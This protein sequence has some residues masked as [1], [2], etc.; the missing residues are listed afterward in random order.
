MKMQ[1]K[2]R[3][4]KISSLKEACKTKDSIISKLLA[5]VKNLAKS[6]NKNK[7]FNVPVGKIVSNE[8]NHTDLSLWDIIS[9]AGDSDDGKSN[10][11]RFSVSLEKQLKAIRK[12]IFIVQGIQ[13]VTV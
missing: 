9:A 1:I 10:K 2:K 11:K 13:K 5:T 6:N 7:D 4:Q 8:Q 3:E 12:K